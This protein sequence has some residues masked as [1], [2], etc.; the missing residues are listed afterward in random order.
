MKLPNGNNPYETLNSE[1]EKRRD[2]LSFVVDEITLEGREG[3]YSYIR[4]ASGI[5]IIALREDGMIP[6]VGQWRYPIEKYAWEFPAGTL[7]EGEEPLETAKR[8]L[9]EEAGL[10]AE[11]W[12]YLGGYYMEPSVS[13]QKSH[14]FLARGLSEVPTNPDE[15]EILELLWIPFEE[16]L[17]KAHAGEIDDAFTAIGLFRAQAHLR[18]EE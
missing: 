18:N 1:E 12:D 10:A 14:V 17:E 11:Q 3:I 4:F 5:G 13:T 6:L 15:D 8:E 16:A 7:E 9:A 2:A